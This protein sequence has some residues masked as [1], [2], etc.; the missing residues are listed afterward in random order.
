M[1]ALG[2]EIYLQYVKE[3]EAVDEEK[4]EEGAAI[5]LVQGESSIADTDEA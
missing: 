3:E 4:K 5:E 2:T 1:G